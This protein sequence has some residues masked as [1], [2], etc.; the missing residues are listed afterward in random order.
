M[1]NWAAIAWYRPL[2]HHHWRGPG[3]LV[4]SDPL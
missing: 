2:Q 1:G 3:H 4:R